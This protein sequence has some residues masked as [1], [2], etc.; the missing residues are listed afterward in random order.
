MYDKSVSKR[1]SMILLEK[2]YLNRI[3]VDSGVMPAARRKDWNFFSKTKEL[4]EFYE[5]VKPFACVSLDVP[6]YPFVYNTWN[7]SKE[8]L[9]DI[10]IQNA[11]KFRDWKPSFNTIKVF[12]LQ[13]T[14]KEEY[15][16]SFYRL[17]ELGIFNLPNV[18]IAFGGLATTGLTQQKE[19]VSYVTNNSKFKEYKNKFKFVHGFGIGNPQ[20]IIELY[21]LGVNS[22]DALTVCIMT[23]T[24][25]YWLR[26][27]SKV[28]H[29]IQESPLTR[30]VRLH[31]NMSSFWGQLAE[32]FSLLRGIPLK[33][34]QE[35]VENL[36][37]LTNFR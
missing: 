12:P 16:E 27:N 30:K 36:D 3:F 5:F 14:T 28:R 10:T 17:E 23:N 6:M 37:K 8:E 35:S 9:L 29:L 15:L 13:G 21:K 33:Q 22:F 18:A 7:K 34:E 4:F 11:I 26:D 2:S 19:I 25:W 20:R 32:K 31:F 1:L 24:G